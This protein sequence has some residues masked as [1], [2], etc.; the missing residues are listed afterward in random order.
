MFLYNYICFICEEPGEVIS[1]K[2]I[3]NLGKE[4]KVLMLSLGGNM[5]GL[6][7]YKEITCLC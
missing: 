4:G 5:N 1:C 3:G 2:G 7:K 6:R